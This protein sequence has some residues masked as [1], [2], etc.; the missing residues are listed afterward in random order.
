MITYCHAQVDAFIF[1]PQICSKIK[2]LSVH[3]I[4]HK[5]GRIQHTSVREKKLF[6]HT[7]MNS[8]IPPFL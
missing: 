6:F 1:I 7:T 2:Y 5:N 8:Q 3:K 4:Y